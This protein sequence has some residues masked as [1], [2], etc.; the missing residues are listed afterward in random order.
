MPAKRATARRNRL[1]RNYTAVFSDL[2][3]GTQTQR[4]IAEKYGVTPMA[5]QK[6]VQRN[7]EALDQASREVAR[8]SADKA[9]A[10]KVWRISEAQR[11]H[12]EVDA[13]LAENGLSET[14]KRYD[15]DGNV[16]GE[17]VRFRKDA[18]DLQ[19]QLRRDVAEEL[20]QLPKNADVTVNNLQV[21]IRQYNGET[22]AI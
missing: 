18:L 19:R 10:D 16:V 8:Y 12:D 21:L 1:E 9:I 6:F 2:V 22:E 11:A 17:T 7:T 13:W 5:V 15:R 4:A 20:G 3:D 14:T